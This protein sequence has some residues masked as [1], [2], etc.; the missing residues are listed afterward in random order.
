MN[1]DDAFLL[2]EGPSEITKFKCDISCCFKRYKSHMAIPRSL[3]KNTFIFII[4][5]SN[6][7]N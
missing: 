3:Y 6:Y 4:T 5:I 1:V 7:D 2:A